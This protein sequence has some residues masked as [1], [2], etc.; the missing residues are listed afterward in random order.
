LNFLTVLKFF[1]SQ[2]KTKKPRHIGQSET[3]NYQCTLKDG[4]QVVREHIS[5]GFQFPRL[6]IFLVPTYLP[7]YLLTAC[8]LLFKS[9][10]YLVIAY[11]PTHV[12]TYRTYFLLNGLARWNQ[13]LLT[14]LKFIHNCCWVIMSIHPVDGGLIWVLLVHSGIKLTSSSSCSALFFWLNLVG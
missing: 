6:T 14:L 10:N 2:E 8:L 7:T 9:S 11:F 1:K 3:S 4:W 13:I 5:V 12:P